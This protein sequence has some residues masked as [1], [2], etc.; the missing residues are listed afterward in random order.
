[1]R[2]PR[3]TF[4]KEQWMFNFYI[5]SM[6]AG[7]SSLTSLTVGD[8]GLDCK[9][10]TQAW[11]LGF[12]L[13]TWQSFE[14]T[15]P[16]RWSLRTFPWRGLWN[17]ASLFCFLDMRK[18]G[19]TSVSLEVQIVTDLILWNSDPKQAFSCKLSRAFCCSDGNLTYG[20]RVCVSKTVELLL[21]LASIP[22]ITFLY[23]HLWNHSG[24]Y[25]EAVFCWAS[26]QISHKVTPHAGGS[27][28]EDT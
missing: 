15:V 25:K 19:Y 16:C 22:L 26:Y 18:Q 24:T 3:R 17:S 12:T 4:G 13:G 9:Y 2:P 20:P 27:P 23:L 7:M 6:E 11:S 21:V 10:P 8:C 14:I 28:K 1:M 5:S